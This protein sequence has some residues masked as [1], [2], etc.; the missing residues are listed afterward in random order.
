M[1]RRTLRV[2]D[3]LRDE[4]AQLVRELKDPRI[5]GLITITAVETSVDLRHARVFVS[6]LGK[7]E[8][9]ETALK[10]LEAAAGFL[11]RQLKAGLTLRR[12]P[13]L[14]FMKDESLERGAYLLEKIK[15]VRSHDPSKEE[16]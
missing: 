4:L 7:D 16:T 13:E 11:H 10:G 2:N 14:S 5:A 12:I 1:K 8:E 3:L 15:E 6:V 9:S